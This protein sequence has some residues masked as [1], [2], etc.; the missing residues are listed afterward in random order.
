METPIEKGIKQALKQIDKSLNDV[1]YVSY[2]KYKASDLQIERYYCSIIEFL[3]A[4]EYASSIFDIVWPF[5]LHI[6]GETWWIDYN[7]YG[8]CVLHDFPTK[9]KN[10]KVPTPSEIL[11]DIDL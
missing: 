7:Y 4:T 10:Y 1:L 5:E 6:V 9:P 8:N 3:K 2:C 11:T